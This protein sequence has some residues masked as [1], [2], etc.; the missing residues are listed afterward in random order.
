MSIDLSVPSVELLHERRSEK[1]ALF[2]RDVLSVT[3]AEMD[4]PL[5]EP[6]AQALRAA[7]ARHGLGYAPPAPASLRRAFAG[8]AARRLRWVVDE[9]QVTLAGDVMQGLVE[10]CR[11]IC[12]PGDSVGFATPAY[13]P[14]FRELPRAGVALT[15]IDLHRDGALELD[16]LD[17]AL[18]AG[19]RVLVLVNPHNPTGL[20]LSRSEL[21]MIAERCAEREVWVL[22]DEIHAP[23]TLAGARHTPWLE[24]SDAARDRGIALTSASKAFN[25]P[26]LKAALIVTAGTRARELVASLAELH[27]HAGLLGVIAAEAAFTDGDDWLDA[28]IDQLD[29]NR[30]QLEREL[31]RELPEIRW[32]PPRATY[33]AWLDC[34]PLGLDPDPA[35]VFLEQGR[36]ALSPGPGYG[37]QGAGHARLNFATSPE[38]LSE[39]VRRMGT[40][41][42]ARA[43]G[44]GGRD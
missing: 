11:A 21:A 34:T 19:I 35:E 2:E 12:A 42:G 4:Y 32:T 9:G 16:A 44:R 14:F 43:A 25:L 30:E 33:L 18:N 10:L 41:V 22:A 3:I 17:A 38:L 29:R 15:G 37:R 13:P 8:F 28:V 6:V 39:A 40:A 5:A 36:V 1:W 26:A 20:V 24:V 27:D 7:I 23:L 31:A